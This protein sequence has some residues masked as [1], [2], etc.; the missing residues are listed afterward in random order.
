MSSSKRI[1]K[2]NVYYHIANFGVDK[3]IIFTEKKDIDLFVSLIDYYRFKDQPSRFSFR[4]REIYSNKNPQEKIVSIITYSIL[5]NH[6]H[7]VLKQLSQNGI[8]I[9]LSK[10]S[11]SYTKSFNAKN[12]RSGPLFSGSF[13]SSPA[14]DQQLITSVS[15]YIHSEPLRI[16]LVTNLQ[17]FPFSSYLE[18]LGL[19]NGFCEKDDILSQFSNINAYQ[20]FVLEKTTQQKNKTIFLE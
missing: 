18:Y 17:R 10:L 15:S 9:F 5:P 6:F 19:E 16:G 8:S 12:N 1:F 14:L 4:G 7:M 2:N 3:K 13:K 20:S 11:N